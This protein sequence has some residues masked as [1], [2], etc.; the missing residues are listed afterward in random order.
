M[1]SV[2][3]PDMRSSERVSYQGVSSRVENPAPERLGPSVNSCGADAVLRKLRGYRPTRPRHAV[4]H[5]GEQADLHLI[6]DR[7][8]AWRVSRYSCSKKDI[9]G[10]GG[11]DGAQA[12]YIPK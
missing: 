8:I 7:P 3:Q 12:K 6:P 5:R 2:G 9:E 1:V 10:S 4:E 11:C